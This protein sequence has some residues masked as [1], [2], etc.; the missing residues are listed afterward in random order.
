MTLCLH[1]LA[2]NRPCFR[3][4]LGIPVESVQARGCNQSGDLLTAFPRLDCTEGKSF[5]LQSHL[6]QRQSC[7]LHASA[8]DSL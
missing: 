6:W 2:V 7:D 1:F 5:L 4:C 8:C 3:D